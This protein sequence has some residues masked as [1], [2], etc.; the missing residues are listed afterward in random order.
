MNVTRQV[1][2]LF[3]AV[4]LLSG[5]APT[6]STSGELN[7]AVA[8]ATKRLDQLNG[9][10]DELKKTN[11]TLE[12]RV[13]TLERSDQWR[14]FVD[15]ASGMAY[16]TPGTDGYAILK[17]DVGFV[18]VSLENVQPYAN[19]TRVALRFGNPTAA[20]LNGGKATLEWGKVDANGLAQNETAKSR[21]VTFTESFGSG[22]WTTV[23]V[24]LEGVPPSELGFVRVKEFS[25]QGMSLRRN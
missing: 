10:L 24:V 2:L 3:A 22:S 14:D 9:R 23:H 18:S 19:G 25:H 13:S 6:G 12:Q 20:V 15:T 8:G 11:A 4:A 7:Q 21:D 1:T 5:C 16:L 17:I